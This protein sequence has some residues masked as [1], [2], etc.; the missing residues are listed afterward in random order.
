MMQKTNV[1]LS[2]LDFANRRPGFRKWFWLQVYELLP[3]FTPS[4][5]DF[6]NYGYAPLDENEYKLKLNPED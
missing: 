4:S 1:F 6:M 3:L 5:L 2:L